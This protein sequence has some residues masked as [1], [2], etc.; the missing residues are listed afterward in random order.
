MNLTAQALHAWDWQQGRETALWH[1]LVHT[2]QDTR[3]EGEHWDWEE[4]TEIMLGLGIGWEEKTETLLGLEVACSL[5]LG[6]ILWLFEL[7]M[8][9]GHCP[10][11]SEVL[12]VAAED[13]LASKE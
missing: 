8:G 6:E 10:S 1:G 5:G 2:S 7:A 13:L 3:R 11:G 4:R 9:S 12:L